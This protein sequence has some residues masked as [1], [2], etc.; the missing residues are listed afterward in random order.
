MILRSEQ[1]LPK[2]IFSNT[3]EILL[4]EVVLQ[5]A[6]VVAVDRELTKTRIRL[7]DCL[8]LALP[9]LVDYLTSQ[10]KRWFLTLMFLENL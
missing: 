5:S 6:A 1:L 8:R 10:R 4:L 2:G 3:I 7:F 9:G